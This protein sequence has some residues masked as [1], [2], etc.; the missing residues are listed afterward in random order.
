MRDLE[1]R[2]LEKDNDY[3]LLLRRLQLEE[4]SYKSQL[5]SE[6][7]RQ[8]KLNTQIDEANSEILRL[9]TAIEVSNLRNIY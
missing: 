4:K 7:S 6:V 5:I 8:K 1:S 9:R 2:L 3:K